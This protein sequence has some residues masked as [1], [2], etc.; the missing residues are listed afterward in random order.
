MKK[1]ESLNLQMK[2][3]AQVLELEFWYLKDNATEKER[4]KAY[5]R[6]LKGAIK[7]DK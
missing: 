1:K 7:N 6:K 5:E 4:L 3:N 2:D